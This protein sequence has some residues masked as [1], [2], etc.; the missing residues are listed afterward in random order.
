MSIKDFFKDTIPETETKVDELPERMQGVIVILN[1]DPQKGG[2]G[3]I[4]S[5]DLPFEKIY[6]HWMSLNQDTLR[7]PELKKGM[8]V[9]FSPYKHIR[10]WRGSKIKVI[11]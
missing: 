9:E 10:G 1:T 5:K 7:F 8:K 3:F 6:F 2:F 11:V 4:Q